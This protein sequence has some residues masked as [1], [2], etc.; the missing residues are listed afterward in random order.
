[1]C[2]LQLDM[3]LPDTA[4]AFFSHTH[5]AQKENMPLLDKVCLMKYLEKYSERFVL[6]ISHS[7]LPLDI[8]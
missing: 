4:Y 3:I 6:L 2:L 8:S 7:V 5:K 1:M